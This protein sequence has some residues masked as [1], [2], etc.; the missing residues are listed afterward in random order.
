MSTGKYSHRPNSMLIWNGVQL[1]WEE[2]QPWMLYCPD[3]W[4]TT[5]QRAV[6][7]EAQEKER[8]AKKL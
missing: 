4:I 6:I 7:R 3:F 5:A 1:L 2:F 8:Q